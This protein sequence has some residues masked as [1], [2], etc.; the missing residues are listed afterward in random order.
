MLADFVA[1]G[2]APVV[3]VTGGTRGIG[4]AIVQAYLERGAQVIATGTKAPAPAT[5]AHPRI[6]HVAVSFEDEDQVRSFAQSLAAL[7]RLDACINNA[8][9]NIIKP[10]SAVEE[11]DYD[12][13]AAIN[14]RAPYF[15]AKAATQVMQKAKRG[16]IVNVGSIW[17]VIAKPGR[18]P[19]CTAKAGLAGMTRALAV[20]LAPDGILVNCVSPGFVL[21]DLTR[22]SL[23]EKER[24][25]LAHLIPLGRMAEPEEIARIVAFLGG[26]ENTYLTGQNI[27]V[28]GGFTHV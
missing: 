11:I 19:Y 7:P 6:H 20:E 14:L 25:A 13:I 4:A 24:E 9:I 27:V 15:I 21:T 2:F 1:H 22:A 8:G 3:L 17:S 28:D 26:P 23:G 10:I 18:T 16:W 12:R 5:P